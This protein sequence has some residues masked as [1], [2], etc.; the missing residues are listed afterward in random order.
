MNN[1]HEYWNRKYPESKIEFARI[2]LP[3]SNI[4]YVDYNEQAEQLVVGFIGGGKYKFFNVTKE[5]FDRLLTTSKSNKKGESPS[6]GS[7]FYYNIRDKYS[8][9]KIG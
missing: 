7:Y 8:Y 4:D 6:Y 2:S 5:S 9:S 1:F 3:S